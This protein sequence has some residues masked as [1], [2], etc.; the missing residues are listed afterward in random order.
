MDV[1]RDL[2]EVF[3]PGHV[4]RRCLLPLVEP[5][6]YIV[7]GTR[8]DILQHTYAYIHMQTRSYIPTPL[9]THTHKHTHTHARTHAHTH[10]HTDTHIHTHTHM[11]AHTRARALEHIPTHKLTH[12]YTLG[13]S[14]KK[15]QNVDLSPSNFIPIVEKHA[16]VTFFLNCLIFRGRPWL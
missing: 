12:T 11:G 3:R 1:L 6:S 4:P 14:L 13:C 5:L 9:T 10:I 7:A 15:L 2:H 16:L 8:K